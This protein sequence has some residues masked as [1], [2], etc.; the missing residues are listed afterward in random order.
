MK[1]ISDGYLQITIS[2]Y[3]FIFLMQVDPKTFACVKVL[4]YPVFAAYS[5]P[6]LYFSSF[7]ILFLH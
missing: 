2:F 1:A 5:A 3:V 4:H 6:L 7:W